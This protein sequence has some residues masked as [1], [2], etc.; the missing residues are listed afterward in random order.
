MRLTYI[1]ILIIITLAVALIFR[2]RSVLCTPLLIGFLSITLGIELVA[3]ILK[4]SYRVNNLGVYNVYMVLSFTFWFWWLTK[5]YVRNRILFYLTSLILLGTS[6]IEIF[7]FGGFNSVHTYVFIVGTLFFV[8]LFMLRIYRA[9]A[10]SDSLLPGY[11]LVF[12][13]AG[14]GFYALFFFDTIFYPTG[15]LSKPVWLGYNWDQILTRFTNFYFYLMIII[16]IIISDLKYTS[17]D[18]NSLFLSKN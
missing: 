4:Y 11:E 3:N 5:S 13:G 16:S 10:I 9:Y 15:L 18:S 1:I 7:F 2:K 12:L 6:I 14:L 8:C 17:L